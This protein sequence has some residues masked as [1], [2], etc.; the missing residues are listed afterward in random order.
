MGATIETNSNGILGPETQCE[1][2]LVPEFADAMPHYC[3]AGKCNNNSEKR[4]DLS[5]HRLPLENTKLLQVWITKMKRDPRHFSVTMHTKICSEHFKEE[6]FIEP[7]AKTRRLNYKKGVLL[8]LPEL[9][10]TRLVYW[11]TE[12]AKESYIDTEKLFNSSDTEGSDNESDSERDFTCGTRLTMHRLSVD[13][14]FLLTFMKLRM[15]LSNIDL[16]V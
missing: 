5:F 9:D 2:G 3:C 10:R 15:A 12:Q 8:I 14:E 11:N 7:E 16:G 1:G 13:N 6:D 4:Q